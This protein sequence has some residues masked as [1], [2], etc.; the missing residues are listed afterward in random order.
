MKK[1]ALL[2]TFLFGLMVT[3][4][5]IAGMKGIKICGLAPHVDV[6]VKLSDNTVVRKV[7][8]DENG[9]VLI[10][11]LYGEHWVIESTS[12]NRKPFHFKASEVP[13]TPKSGILSV[14]CVKLL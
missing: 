8:T 10:K 2:I 7:V 13:I 9:I 3:S 11:E 12:A 1:M 5:A 4:S 6:L 14:G